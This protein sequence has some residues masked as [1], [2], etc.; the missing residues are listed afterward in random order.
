MEA[1]AQLFANAERAEAAALISFMRA[2]E[3]SISLRLGLSTFEEGGAVAAFVPAADVL[4]L[5][6]VIGLGVHTPASETQLD[7]ILAAAKSS[8]VHRLFLQLTPDAKPA[9]L[10]KW[11]EARGATPHNRW[12]RL[13]R[14]VHEAPLP[15]ATLKV[16]RVDKR[17]ADAFAHVVRV[18]FAMP[19]VVEPWLTSL[20]GKPGW[21]HYV[22]RNQSKV[23]AT[24]ALFKVREFAWF[25]F[26][27]TLAE[28]RG[29]GAQS[30][31]VAAR[32]R[33][34]DDL[35]CRI[36]VTETMEETPEHPVQSYRNMLRL[37]FHEAYRRQNYVITLA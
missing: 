20:V 10:T 13:W 36:A 28:H 4:A 3:R 26:T 11:I 33:E 17:H 37:G 27:A 12:V 21:S 6:R 14:G 5:N 1:P 24:S 23:V 34:A 16:V 31:L 9:L 7:R 29:A 22:T 19:E 35:G 18:A 32:L 30:S 25:G 2:P 8:G 15:E